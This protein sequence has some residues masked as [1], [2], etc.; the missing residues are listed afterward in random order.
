[1]LGRARVYSVHASPAAAP[2]DWVLVPEGFS[3]GAFVFSWMWLAYRRLWLALGLFLGVLV[4][5]GLAR[6]LTGFDAGTHATLV[7]AAMVFLGLEGNDLRRARLEA[8]GWRELGVVG[9]RSLDEAEVAMLARFA[10]AAA[11]AAPVPQGLYQRIGPAAEG[12]MGQTMPGI[13]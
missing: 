10:P 11:V 7:L 9:A 6:V 13:A 3:W 2:E 8:R 1:M 4:A 12:G 5:I